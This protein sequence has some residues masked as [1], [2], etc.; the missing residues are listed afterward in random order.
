MKLEY[1]D[2]GRKAAGYHK[3]ADD[4]VVRAIAIASELPYQQVHSDIGHLASKERLTKRRKIRSNP[5]NGVCKTTY[6]PYIESLG[7]TWTPCMGIGTGCRIRLAN[8]DLPAGR[9]IVRLSRH[10]TA[11]I[12]GIIH[13]TYNPQRTTI[14]HDRLTGKV[15]SRQ[16]R[17]VYGYWIKG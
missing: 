15:W 5:N 8:D 12:N 2:G 4:C 3:Q 16:T 13:D 7:F 17:C 14:H 9:L 1:N 11:V 6:K 10:I